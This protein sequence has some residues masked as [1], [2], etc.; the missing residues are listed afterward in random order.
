MKQLKIAKVAAL[1]HAR[2]LSTVEFT[3]EI[4]AEI[5]LVVGILEILEEQARWIV[6]PDEPADILPLLWVEIIVCGAF[7]ERAAGTNEC[8]NGDFLVNRLPMK[9]PTNSVETNLELCFDAIR[10][11]VVAYKVYF[12]V[13]CE[14]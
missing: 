6:R 2:L 11:V 7:W 5:K 8:C 4:V 12:D 9:E 1:R 13:C 3:Q 14:C 10:V